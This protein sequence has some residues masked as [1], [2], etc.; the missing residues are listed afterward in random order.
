MNLSHELEFSF[1]RFTKA[2][3]PFDDNRLN[4]KPTEKSWSAGQVANHILKSIN[5]IPEFFKESTAVADRPIDLHE[6]IIR[7]I[8]LD[9]TTKM[10]SPD[11]ILPETD[12]EFKLNEIL[13]ELKQHQDQLLLASTNNNL[14]LLCT[15]FEF[16]TIGH[17]TQYEWLVFISCHVQ[18]HAV[19]LENIKK[20]LNF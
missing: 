8:F 6:A 7:S 3:D 1:T 14:K 15:S 19:Q 12:K 20:L 4:M 11:F 5:N 16:P 18:R 2:I 13:D 10:Q 9:F 17:L